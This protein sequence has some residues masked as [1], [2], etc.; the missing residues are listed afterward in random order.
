MKSGTWFGQW[1]SLC[2]EDLKR[3]VSAAEYRDIQRERERA[4][5]RKIEC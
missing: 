2:A 4:T 5:V 1:Y 3:A